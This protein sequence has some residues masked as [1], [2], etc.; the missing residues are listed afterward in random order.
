MHFDDLTLSSPQDIVDAFSSF[1]NQVYL[2][3]DPEYTKRVVDT[4]LHNIISITQTS[5]DEI[6]SSQKSFKASM[7]AGLDGIPSFLLRDCAQIFVTQLFSIFNLIIKSSTF[8]TVWKQ[9]RVS[10]IFKKEDLSN[11]EHFRPISIICNF[12]KILESILY[13][14]FNYFL[15]NFNLLQNNLD[16]VVEWSSRNRLSLNTAKCFFPHIPGFVLSRI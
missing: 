7:T 2:A 8:P 6:I 14:D 11:I 12:S 5:E 15:I 10:P 13:S 9:A 16:A 4:N 1:F 3:S